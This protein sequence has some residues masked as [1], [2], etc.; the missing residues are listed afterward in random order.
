MSI[1]YVGKLSLGISNYSPTDGVA[2]PNNNTF[3]TVETV[4][5]SL[6]VYDP[7]TLT[8][9]LSATTLAAPKG[10]TLINNLSAV[11]TSNTQTTI[12]LIELSSGF[13]QN[14]AGGLTTIGV[15]RTTGGQYVAGDPSTNVAWGISTTAATMV[16]INGNNF[17]VST[18][19]ISEE[20]N[21]SEVFY[22]VILR[23]PGRW[24]AGT[25]DGSIVEIDSSGNVT[26]F[27]RLGLTEFPL[28]KTNSGGGNQGRNINNMAYDSNILTLSTDAAVVVMDWSTKTILKQHPSPCSGTNPSLMLSNSASGVALACMADA[29]ALQIAPMEMDLTI[30]PLTVR[31]Q[32]FLDNNYAPQAIGV[33]SVNGNAFFLNVNFGLIV[34]LNISPR[35]S[36]LRNII[37][38]SASGAGGVNQQGRLTIVDDTSGVGFS[39]VILDTYMTSPATYRVPAGAT[40]IEFVKVGLG[41]NATWDLTRYST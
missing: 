16:K 22:C 36:T 17:T 34:S 6:R 2:N 9:L 4:K 15:A 32:V 1:S 28:G 21:T 41:S 24:L 27:Y 11:V 37:I 26:D 3:V 23:V 18:A 13:R 14:Y 30:Q 20:L 12:D 40:L 33:N 5:P 10:V 38:Q 31:D 35:V 8:Q 25:N 39:K 29:G 7:S 19:L